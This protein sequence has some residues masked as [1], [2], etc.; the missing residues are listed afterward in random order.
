VK[1]LARIFGIALIVAPASAAVAQQGFHMWTAQELATREA[2]LSKTVGAD[3]SSRETLADYGD[4][5]FRLLYRNGDGNPEEH[6]AVID[7]VYV[8][9]GTG[10]LVLGGTMTG[11]RSTTAGEYVGTGLEGGERH[12]LGAGDIAHIPAGV[13][14]RFLV[15]SGGHF[16]YVLVKIP[17]R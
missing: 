16:T 15:P 4:H 1:S 14:H 3:R 6:G 10:T 5:R 17:S 7:I 9:S 13:P 12:P 11:R 8:Q 2:A